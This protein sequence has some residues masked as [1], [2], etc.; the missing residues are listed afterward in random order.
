[1]IKAQKNNT[2]CVFPWLQLYV[3]NMGKFYSCCLSN[4]VPS[5]ENG[6]PILAGEKDSIR[7]HWHSLYMQGLRKT[8]QEG[9]RAET[10]THC[11]VRED[12]GDTSLRFTHFEMSEEAFNSSTP[13]PNFKW[14]DL[15]FGNACNLACRMCIPY[16]TR[17]LLGEW[18]ELYGED[19]V[20]PYRKMD[21]FESEDFWIQLSQFTSQ[22]ER[23]HL[24]G[25]EPL[26]IKQCWKFLRGLVES[27]Q[28]RNIT[29]AYNTNLTVLPPEALELW[30]K[31]KEVHLL[32]SLDG[33]GKVGEYIRYPLNW[34]SFEQNVKE[35]EKRFKDYNISISHFHVTSQ[36]YNI[37]R[38]IEICEYAAQYKNID[39]V[40]RF[41]LLSSPLHFDPRV[42]PRE[43]R[44]EA[45]SEMDAYIEKIKS[46]HNFL[47]DVDREKL[48]T[49]LTALTR[50]LRG[51]DSSQ[52]F[53]EFKR[54][55]DLM[56]RHR[57]QRTFDFLPELEKAYK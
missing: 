44:E 23:I 22:T 16:N 51:G 15:R 25:G 49:N 1:M 19:S 40:P 43:Y 3:D 39:R 20:A 45:A 56:D 5:M 27:G 41:D 52:H 14:I 28:S 17:K 7:R 50:Y 38:T 4:I 12:L 34:D 48:V 36:V 35:I 24:A 55:T 2:A 21:W 6:K 18:Q 9:K 26:L 47:S 33:V 42:L 31:F 29:L 53:H 37:K 57:N 54:H 32:I 46:G 11:W 8:M 30:P 10:C 13:E